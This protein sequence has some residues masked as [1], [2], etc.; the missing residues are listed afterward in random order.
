[1]NKVVDGVGPDAEVVT[2]DKGGKQSKAPYAFHL[3]DAKSLLR[4]AQVM[5]YGAERYERDNWRRIP[6]EEHIN[7]A[8]GHFML[9]L[10]G[11]TQD[12]HIGHALCRA[13][14]AD[15]TRNDGSLEA[16]AE[17]SGALPL[18]EDVGDK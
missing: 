18:S 8:V 12:D 2:N 1:V 6:C 13:M 10:A 9:A 4:L 5:A 11:D 3:C 7:H 15:A 14:M 17:V 16:R